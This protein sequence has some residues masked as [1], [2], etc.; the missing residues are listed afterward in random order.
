MPASGLLGWTLIC[1]RSLLLALARTLEIKEKEKRQWP[2]LIF[3]NIPYLVS[4][5]FVLLRGR[6][7]GM[8]SFCISLL[9]G[10]IRSAL[11]SGFFFSINWLTRSR[12]NREKAISMDVI[13]L[14]V[15]TTS[16]SLSLSRSRLFSLVLLRACTSTRSWA[17]HC[18]RW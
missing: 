7:C 14:G 4:L 8:T 17:I 6:S 13:L 3:I 1:F 11:L 9:S 16:L 10:T 15:I 18:A 5:I 2:W 12:T